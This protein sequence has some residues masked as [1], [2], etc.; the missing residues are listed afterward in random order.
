MEAAGATDDREFDF[1]LSFAGEDRDVAEGIAQILASAGARVFYDRWFRSRLLGERLAHR[2]ELDQLYGPGAHF[3]VPI[4]SSSYVERDY[5]RYEFAAA[6]RE[7]ARR[8]AAF[9]LP[10]RLDDMPLLGLRDDVGYIDLRE[11][12]IE[13]AASCLLAKLAERLQGLP[14]ATQRNWIATFGLS[15]QALH[16]ERDLPGDAPA[17]YAD[18]C[19]WLQKGLLARLSQNGIEDAR[20]V[21]DLRTGETFSV[22]VAFL[23]DPN[24]GPL[25]FGLLDWWEI[26]EVRPYGQTYPD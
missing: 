25:D 16:D 6:R 5:P 19:D 17:T 4:V 13:T 24:S 3:V 18:L 7:Q 22:R 8:T 14:R 10:L 23:W 20:A 11:V 21:E 9:I 1:A 15:I 26:L 12:G 2:G